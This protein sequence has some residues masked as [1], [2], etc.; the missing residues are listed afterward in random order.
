[1]LYVV[2]TINKDITL[3]NHDERFI[4]LSSYLNDDVYK[5]IKK[6]K[7]SQSKNQQ[8]QLLFILTKSI[9]LIHFP[10]NNN[11]TNELILSLTYIRTD[12]CQQYKFKYA[13][14]WYCGIRLLIKHMMNE[15]YFK[16]GAVDNLCSFTC[17]LTEHQYNTS[18]Y[19]KIPSRVSVKL[20]NGLST[21]DNH[22]PSINVEQ[23]LEYLSSFLNS[24]ISELIVHFVYQLNKAK[25]T[26]LT[27]KLVSYIEVLHEAFNNN[28]TNKL[29][30]KLNYI[31]VDLCQRHTYLTTESVIVLFQ[32]LIKHVMKDGYFK[33]GSV[34]ELMAFL[35]PIKESQY[36]IS[37]SEII[38]EDISN[39]FS[40]KPSAERNFK[41]VLNS[42]CTEEI[43][44]RFEE[45]V[46]TFKIKKNHR[47]PL[48][49][50][51]EQIFA[52]NT[53]WH[54]HPKIIQGE[55]LKFRGNLL[56]KFHRN[57]AYGKFQNVKNSLDVLVKHGLLPHDLDI[58]DNL[59]RCT[60]TQKIRKNNPLICEINMYDE[61]QRESYINTPKFI[62]YL[63]N[64]LSNNLNILVA[65]AQEIVSKGYKKFCEKE[66][67]IAQSQFN[68]FINH[69]KLLVKN[70]NRNSG[71]L[72]V[73]P[74]YKG[75]PRRSANITAYYDHF[76]DAMV[77]GNTPH[78]I[79]HLLINDESLQYLGLTVN[80]ASAMQ[81][82]ITEEIGINPYSL[83]RVKTASNGH[84]LEFVQ[85]DNEGTVRIK[86]LKP[87]A[88]N[89]S[90]RNAA[91]AFT[92]LINMNVKEINAATCLKMALEMTSRSRKSLGVK[93]LWVCLSVKGA[94]V[95]NLTSFQTQFKKIRE[96]ASSKSTNLQYATLKKVRISKGVLIYLE[97]NGDS[98]KTATY[99]GNTVKTTLNNYIPKYLT[100]L[101]HRVKI[102]NFQK[103]FLF[104]AVSSDESPSKSLN[105]SESDF[106]I[107]LN[108]AFNNP[109]MN[110]DLY[111]KLTN[112]INNENEDVN[113]LYFCVS[114]LN[115]QLAI[116][117][118]KY[119]EDKKLKKNCKDVLNKIGEE[120]SVIMKVMLRK[121]Q[122][123]ANEE[124]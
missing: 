21:T 9:E 79:H 114:D 50:F 102:R 36:E 70:T 111:E 103:I 61:M 95:A 92:S 68:E 1:M 85:I 89:A 41:D 105:I 60:N 34:D 74:F 33:D 51:L 29:T 53:E 24:D 93:E 64:D 104:M 44:S 16:K 7:S 52:I 67:F 37:K 58:P 59:R 73:N 19:K 123:A 10:F 90:T 27:F 77:F 6:Y 113:P 71:Y 47:A 18:K 97:T 99:L 13:R 11:D 118:A 94:T 112:K 117:Y 83:Y 49:T 119:G 81:I 43:A 82:I 116:R 63:K 69:P 86:A 65:D 96:Q 66:N 75:H 48:I 42:C 106:K 3:L 57:T 62:E 39:L 4:F 25:Q 40:H 78:D 115:L 35:I 32:Q 28:D 72:K 101:I 56:D 54:K 46:N 98:L 12:L 45:H 2:E 80:V 91:G 23:R 122:I 88:R 20:N 84:G 5:L 121:A 17:P 30:Q 15:G 120:S 110:G 100:E 124:K 22:L 38:P 108:K 76:F 26:I 87:R 8:K 107:Q 109:D 31:R 55:L 14:N